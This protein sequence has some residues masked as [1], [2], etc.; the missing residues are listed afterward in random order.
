MIRKYGLAADNVVDAW[1]VDVNGKI[2]DRESM[3]EDLFWAIRGGGGA[4]F[5]IVVAWKVNLVDVPEKVSVFSLSKTLDQ[6]ASDLF[7]K[8]QYKG[9]KLSE[10]LFIRIR[11]SFLSI[12]NLKE[13]MELKFGTKFPPFLLVILIVLCSSAYSKL[14]DDKFLKCLS[15]DSPPNATQSEFSTP[16][17]P[18][19]IAIITPLTYFHVQSTVLCSK[20]FGY[21]IWIRSGGHDNAGLSYTS[22]DQTPFVVLDL[23]ELRK[24][25]I[26]SSEKTAW[27]ESGATVGELYYWVSQESRDLGFPAGICP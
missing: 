13:T 25:T 10:D 24:I 21:R 27:V 12:P 3:G 26:H 22:Y 4:S 16:T 15:Q 6:G 1:I 9:H 17:T 20:S 14:M 11:I 18:K 23:K 7:N 5:G 8:W 2:L 19:P